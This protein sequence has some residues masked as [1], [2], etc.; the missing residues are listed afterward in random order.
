[1]SDTTT[2]SGDETI[3]YVALLRRNANY[4][5]LWSGQVVSLL[6]DWFNLIASA[7]LVASLTQS[8]ISKDLIEDKHYMLHNDKFV[9]DYRTAFPLYLQY[10]ARARKDVVIRDIRQSHALIKQEP[11]F[12]QEGTVVGFLNRPV[13]VLS[14]Q[15]LQ[16]KGID[17]SMFSLSSELVN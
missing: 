6:G 5:Y 11:Y 17:V 7:S 14:K 3:G 10:C 16:D 13:M 9:L 4:R 12:E 1:M 2:V 8:G 15:G